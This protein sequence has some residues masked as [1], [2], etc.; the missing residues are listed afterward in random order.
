MAGY[1]SV[2]RVVWLKHQLQVVLNN[3][4]VQVATVVAHPG[5][6]NTAANPT[7][8]TATLRVFLAPFTFMIVP[9]SEGSVQQPSNDCYQPSYPLSTGSK[10]NFS[11]HFLYTFVRSVCPVQQLREGPHRVG[12]GRSEDPTQS[13]LRAVIT[14]VNRLSA[15]E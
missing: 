4:T 13:A 10:P 5:R 11:H 1:A 15:G 2:Q 14:Y 6:V 12:D 8:A 3:S 7:A 9:F